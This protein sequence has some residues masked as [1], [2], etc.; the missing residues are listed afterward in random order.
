MNLE[1]IVNPVTCE[2]FSEFI[3]QQPNVAVVFAAIWHS[4][5]QDLVNKIDAMAKQF[6]DKLLVGQADYDLHRPLFSLRKI[7]IVPTLVVYVSGKEKYRFSGVLTD[8]DLLYYLEPL[9]LA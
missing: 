2:N 7:V 6:G 5:S 1:V 4:T 3:K 8:K 9:C